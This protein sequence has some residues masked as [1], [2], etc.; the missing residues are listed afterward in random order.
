MLS[1]GRIYKRAIADHA[2]LHGAAFVALDQL[3]HAFATMA[4]A[5]QTEGAS[6]DDCIRFQDAIVRAL[7][8]AHGLDRAERLAALN[9]LFTAF[10]GRPRHVPMTVI[11]A[12]F[13]RQVRLTGWNAPPPL[14]FHRGLSRVRYHSVDAPNL[15]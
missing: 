11:R 4:T 15:R 14:A 12:D 2:L 5:L 9:I 6:D 10:D 13:L 3:G 8:E 7:N 1:L